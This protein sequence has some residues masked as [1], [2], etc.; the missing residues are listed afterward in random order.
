ML[1]IEISNFRALRNV[2]LALDR[3]LSVIVGENESGKSTLLQAIKW[4]CTGEAYGHKGK[5]APQAL[6]TYGEDKLSVRM[7]LG[8][9][10]AFRTQ[11]TGTALKTVAENLGCSADLLPLLFDAEM[12][13]D[14]GSKSL[15]AFFS[16]IG[17]DAFRP[18]SHFANDPGILSCIEAA[19]RVGAVTTKKII[20]HC[21][22]MRAASKDPAR[23]PMPAMAEPVEAT[24]T[25]Q[26]NLVETARQIKDARAAE[27][28]TI[29]ARA[30]QLAAIAAYLNEVANYKQALAQSSGT[31]PLGERRRPLEIVANLTAAPLHQMAAAMDAVGA[32]TASS[33]LRLAASEV[34]N[35]AA[36]SAYTLKANP[37]PK[38]VPQPPPVPVVTLTEKWEDLTPAQIAQLA[39]E[40]YDIEADLRAKAQI[41]AH[42]MQQQVAIL[43]SLQQAV[44]AWNSYRAAM[45]KYEQAL[46]A[47]RVAWDRWDNAAKS[48]ALA[49]ADFLAKTAATFAELISDFTADILNGRK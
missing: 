14:G 3:P 33:A 32:T 5:E 10:S 30:R 37:P 21:E 20:Q 9:F 18:G 25:Q 13:G 46:E 42:Y 35:V 11:S 4:A 29:Q 43:E 47:A 36:A 26:R 45:P 6:T 24:I 2:A 23:P 38:T 19:T 41:D 15:K 39:K 7:T 49:E 27:L 31:D 12:C 44:G 22:S 17:A 28:A 48:I 16:A 8:D 34:T 1:Q 40:A